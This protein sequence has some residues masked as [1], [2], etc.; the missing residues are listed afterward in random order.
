MTQA[1]PASDCDVVSDI[2]LMRSLQQG[3]EAAMCELIARWE[4][5]PA[6]ICLSLHPKY[7]QHA[8]HRAGNIR[9]VVYE[10]RTV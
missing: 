9:A 5:R 6:F 2:E 8:G 4:K 1:L 10:A 7:P 3:S